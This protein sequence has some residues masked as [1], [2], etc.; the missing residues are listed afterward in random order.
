MEQNIDRDLKEAQN[1][2]KEL[3]EFLPEKELTWK[4][5][6]K[7][8]KPLLVELQEEDQEEA[9]AR[10]VRSRSTNMWEDSVYKK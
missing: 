3:A 9:L 5:I 8:V 1:A 6:V 7:L 4:N 10:K 2:L